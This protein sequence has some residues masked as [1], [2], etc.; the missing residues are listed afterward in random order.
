MKKPE[1]SSSKMYQTLK[2][3]D[4]Y[5]REKPYLKD[6]KIK[7]HS[8][9]L[10]TNSYNNIKKNNS[11]N[12][13]NQINIHKQALQTLS[14]AALN[15][16]NLLSD[17][18]INVD[19]EDK[20]IYHIEDELK[21]IKKKKDNNFNLFFL[22][23]SDS[24]DNNFYNKEKKNNNNEKE[25]NINFNGKKFNGKKK[26]KNFI[27]DDENDID[28]SLIGKFK[29]VKLK[30]KLTQ[31]S[32]KNES[33]NIRKKLTRNSVFNENDLKKK[34]CYRKYSDLSLTKNKK[35]SRV[36]FS[37]MNL[38]SLDNNFN[39]LDFKDLKLKKKLTENSINKIL[40]DS[41]SLIDDQEEENSEKK[42]RLNE[43]RKKL[44]K[45]KNKI[46]K[47]RNSLVSF[48]LKSS[49]IE[50]KTI[51]SNEDVNLSIHYNDKSD[52]RNYIPLSKKNYKKFNN[53]C[54]NI[55]K[56]FISSSKEN[57]N[58]REKLNLEEMKENK[59]SIEPLKNKILNL[60][61]EK[62]YK[63]EEENE[64]KNSINSISNFS[65]PDVIY[66][67]IH[68]R[69]LIK[70]N[71]LVY[72]SFS[73][74]EELDEIEGEFFFEPN[75]NF[76]FF[77]DMI[78]LFLSIYA[79]I[80]PPLHFSFHFND[81]I[82]FFS[83]N[84]IME[85]II[86]IFFFS[87][88]FLGFFTGFLDFE[89]QLISNNK[90]IIINYLKT[91]FF[92]DLISGIPINSFFIFLIN[93]KKNK[94]I[95][96]YI[97][98][99]WQILQ[100]LRFLRL[101]KLFKTFTHNSFTDYILNKINSIDILVK[102]FTLYISLFIFFASVHLLS[103]IFIYLSQLDFPN[104]IYTNGFELNDKFGIYI[105]SL[106]YIAA[107]VFTIGYGDIVSIS[108]YERFFN[109]ILLVVGI[110]IYSFA[111][112]A[113]SNYVQSVDCKT[114]DY[115]NK[116][117]ILKQIRV[118]HEK[119]PQ[120]LFDK[121]SKFLLY[122]LNNETKE[123][124]EIVDNL[125][126]VLRNNLI[127]E[128][129]KNIIDNFIFFKS[130]ENT[131]FIIRVLLAFKPFQA[132]KNER[133]VNDGDYLE[134]IF[135]VKRGKLALEIPLP[136]IIKDETLKKI[137]TI[138]RTRESIK[139]GFKKSMIPINPIN[140]IS[141]IP[142]YIETQTFND[143]KIDKELKKLEKE[144]RP[145]QQYI[146]IIEI[147]RN[148]HF[149]DILMFLNKRSPLSVKVKSKVC[150]LFLLKKTD[151]VEISMSFPKIWR[152]IIKKSLFNMGQI[153]ILIKKTLKFFFIHNEGINNK[154]SIKEN[155][156]RRIPSM[157]NKLYNINANNLLNSLKNNSEE[158]YEL[159]SIPSDENEEMKEEES[160]EE[161]EI[162]SEEE[163][164]NIHNNENKKKKSTNIDT[165]ID[166]V[167]ENI[168]EDSKSKK[169]YNN[170]SEL[171]SD[172]SDYSK[173]KTETS[174]YS[175]N[176]KKSNKTLIYDMRNDL[177]FDLSDSFYEK[178]KGSLISSDNKIYMYS[179]EDINNE[180]IPFEDDILIKNNESSINLFPN[181]LLKHSSLNLSNYNVIVDGNTKKKKN[182]D[183]LLI[184][185]NKSNSNKTEANTNSNQNNIN[186]NNSNNNNINYNNAN[187]N[188][189]NNNNNNKNNN[190]N[191]NNK[192]NNNNNLN[193]NNNNN[194]NNSNLNYKSSYNSILVENQSNCNIHLKPKKINLKNVSSLFEKENPLSDNQNIPRTHSLPINNKNVFLQNKLTKTKSFLKGNIDNLLLESRLLNSKKRLSKLMFQKEKN[195]EN[196]IS[197]SN[198]MK[199]E[200]GKESSIIDLVQSIGNIELP[201]RRRTTVKY[202]YKNQFGKTNTL[203]SEK[204]NLNHS[205]SIE[206]RNNNNN[207]LD[208]ISENIEKNSLN[209]NNPQFFYSSYF[210]SVMNKTDKRKTD[211]TQRLKNIAKIIENNCKKRY[212]EDN[213]NEKK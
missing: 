44:K 213:K 198:T 151:A 74:E 119:M 104:W 202:I 101:F 82:N 138:K 51:K 208:L 114:Q 169:T 158:N 141:S 87:D 111:V 159:Q 126:V 203:K 212:S 188:H 187:N 98:Y 52:I 181:S 34:T 139:F 194:A 183:N 133:L 110:M 123:K 89:E 155:Y 71:K 57:E 171:N 144:I 64:L 41:S 195:N 170:I 94:I 137:E 192:N 31:N 107:T 175:I 199:K 18:L 189:L 182:N 84:I 75:G 56:S 103:C 112:S 5:N 73:D 63:K 68:F 176:S 13:K 35:T 36:K 90:S 33:N 136:V 45:D 105:T 70:Q 7:K 95:L 25:D 161:E 109:L 96:S 206:K 193:D 83:F 130:F 4:T 23:K 163:D 148:E 16:K 30:K 53:I 147:R 152:K 106:Y 157:N 211:V 11:N 162:I 38:K 135:F 180:E 8:S 93:G 26:Y 122:R 186:Y 91:W 115:I 102:W 19:P 50:K 59:K 37:D 67:E 79:I 78:L 164:N 29:S 43:L 168:S 47:K 3:L 65:D 48:P 196:Q 20:K 40:N 58:L 190:G 120:S 14:D 118:S 166:E 32:L 197:I 172:D 125:P 42:N 178:D 54:E 160:E 204:L 9:S 142:N 113:L 132:S 24:D 85:F 15:M 62:K 116:M 129:Y 165:V 131:D 46:Y 77:H 134:E 28:D 55:K 1:N 108:I 117:S 185:L 201:K 167:D 150:E 124:N 146:K 22:N 209:L 61:H 2:K 12:E 205:P 154:G 97:T 128:M 140:R 149:G 86:D 66:K 179:N 27:F 191:N 69:R 207:M 99:N 200:N 6:L 80:F 156:F 143:S 127:I 121:I 60:E 72:D 174:K 92:T 81:D 210:S 153:E 145:Q 173:S 177:I 184:L 88:F 49:L 39:Y 17:F 76:I 10:I 100:L 21:R